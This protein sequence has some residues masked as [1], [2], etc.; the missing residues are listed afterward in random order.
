MNEG[1]RSHRKRSS[2]RNHAPIGFQLAIVE[3]GDFESTSPP[4]ISAQGGGRELAKV[5]RSGFL[6]GRVSLSASGRRPAR[7]PPQVIRVNIEHAGDGGALLLRQADNPIRL[8]TEPAIKALTALGHVDDRVGIDCM[9]D[10]TLGLS[11]CDTGAAMGTDEWFCFC[12]ESGWCVRRLTAFWALYGL[13]HGPDVTT[14]TRLTLAS[15]GQEPRDSFN[16][17][18]RSG[19]GASHFSTHGGDHQT[20]RC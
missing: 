5:M 18:D 4:T 2:C 13:P 6:T 17:F 8:P 20:E 3:V 14:L 10:R 1:R 15:N 7:R 9:A 11:P 12:W 16:T 19:P